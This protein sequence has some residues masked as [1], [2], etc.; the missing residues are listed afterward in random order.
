MRGYPFYA[1]GGN[2]LATVSLG[3]RF[4]LL[5]KI[6]TRILQLYFDKLY[7][8]MYADLGN[9]WTGAVPSLKEFKKDAGVQLRLESFSF[10]AFPTRVFFDA[11]YGFDRFT[12]P[13]PYTGQ[14]VTYGKEWRFYF[15]VLF[16]FDFD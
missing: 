9:A 6:D 11:A 12:R 7:A 8:F 10:Y 4:P 1:I 13:I 5:N 2:E 16:G 14:R 3:Y 15:G